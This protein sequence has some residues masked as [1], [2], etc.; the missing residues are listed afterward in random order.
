MSRRVVKRFE[1]IRRN[2]YYASPAEIRRREMRV[3]NLGR[4][5]LVYTPSG[6]WSNQL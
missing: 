2:S 1:W 3:L 4:W 5:M 6:H